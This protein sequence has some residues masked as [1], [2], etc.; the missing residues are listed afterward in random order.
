[1]YAAVETWQGSVV[2]IHVAPDAGAPM[3]VVAEARALAGR[4]L[5]GDRYAL[6]R[7]HYSPNPSVGGRELT[8]IESEALEALGELGVKLSA[9]ETRR[10]VA[11]VTP[12]RA[13]S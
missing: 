12:A 13:R 9:A 4:G 10:N 8:L 6:R 3:V 2:S 11:G 5:E 1:M 7:G